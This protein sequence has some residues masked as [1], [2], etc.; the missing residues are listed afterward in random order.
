MASG[1]LHTVAPGTAFFYRR[2][3]ESMLIEMD[4]CKAVVRPGRFFTDGMAGP[5]QR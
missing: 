3:Q 5:T 1:R 4:A 2:K